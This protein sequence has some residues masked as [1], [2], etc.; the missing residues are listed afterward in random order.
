MET[1]FNFYFFNMIFSH[2][3]IHEWKNKPERVILD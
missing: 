1:Y 3:E 2:F